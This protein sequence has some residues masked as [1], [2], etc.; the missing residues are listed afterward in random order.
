MK[1]PF[2]LAQVALKA[3][4]VVFLLIVIQILLI[5]PNPSSSTQSKA[6]FVF[7]ASL[8]CIIV[9]L[10]YVSKALSKD[11]LWAQVCAYII[12]IGFGVLAVPILIVSVTDKEPIDDLWDIWTELWAVVM[13][14]TIMLCIG[15][16]SLI[17]QKSKKAQNIKHAISLDTEETFRYRRIIGTVR[18]S[19]S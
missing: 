10:L 4:A 1:R 11:K 15:I 17:F 3:Y 14:F 13:W 6:T 16:I 2:M 19:K 12:F 18:L 9:V 5:I 8:V 7:A